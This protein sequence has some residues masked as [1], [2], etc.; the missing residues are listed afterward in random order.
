M[1]REVKDE[2]VLQLEVSSVEE[3]RSAAAGTWGVEEDYVV[4]KVIE[5]E[6]KLFGLL[7]KKLRVEVS[8]SAPLTSIKVRKHA[9]DMLTFMELRVTPVV[10]PDG[11]VDLQGDDSG[12]VIGRYGE[13]M[14][15]LEY[16][17]NLML[18]DRAIGHRVHFDCGGYKE[19]REASITRL[20][21]ATARDVVRTG[22]S[23][24][25]DCMSSWERRVVH[26]A[27]QNDTTVE[28]K[29]VGDE[30]LRKVMVSPRS[31]RRYPTRY[32]ADSRDY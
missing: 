15:A 30:P 25:L 29:S 26:V 22:Q 24:I 10:K 3:A 4:V 9:H 6:K 14:K 32:K 16:L 8:T 19:R 12:I 2:E 20:A 7:G 18:Y 13:T 5:E 17:S 21:R 27:L 1:I 31:A 23:E 11:S 28:T